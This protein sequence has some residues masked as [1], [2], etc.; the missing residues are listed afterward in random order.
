[1]L[2][3]LKELLDQAKEEK[4][5]VGAFNGTTLEAIRGIIQAAEELDTPVILQHAQSHDDIID[6]EEIGPIMLYYAERA[7][8]PVALHLDHGS[9]FERCVQALRL[10]FTSVMYDASAKSFEE[11]VEETKEIVKIA[12]AVGA[13]VEA[14]LGHIFTSEVVHGEG[15]E[16]DSKDDYENLDDIYTDP[17]VAKEFVEKTGV[18]CLA[19]AFGT[20]HGVYL[21]EPKLDLPRVAKIREAANVPLVMHGG[22]GV[23]DE[24]YKVAIENGI[25]KVN[26]Y[27][28]MNTAGGKA[29]KDYWADEERPLFYDSMSLAATEAI[30]EDVKKAIKVFQKK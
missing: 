3:T 15:G 27:T 1:M 8:V 20:T 11:N 16:S 12:H 26:Y 30:K 21:T 23:S 28:Y 14:E 7:K 18:D 6:L 2:V 29:S 13:S 4:K 5:A 9:S 25:C 10:G 19:V 22:S 17:Q 24:D